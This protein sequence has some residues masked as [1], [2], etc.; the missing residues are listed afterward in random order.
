MQNKHIVKLFI[1][2]AIALLLIACLLCIYYNVIKTS[3]EGPMDPWAIVLLSIPTI[4]FIASY[5]IIK[6]KKID[7]ENSLDKEGALYKCLKVVGKIFFVIVII[8]FFPIALVVALLTIPTL[9]N[10]KTFKKLINKGF[11]YAYKDKKY[12]LKR[13]DIVIEIQLGLTDYYISFDNGNTFERVEDSN[14]GTSYE[15]EKL[16]QALNEY[17]NA[18]PVDKQRGDALPPLNDY[19]EFLNLY[20]E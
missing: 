4:T 11:S 3:H 15:R 12:I 18:H 5:I 1:F 8:I 17:E 16:K 10:K 19:I 6:I 2:S 9:P 13:K 7:F 20:I 14:L